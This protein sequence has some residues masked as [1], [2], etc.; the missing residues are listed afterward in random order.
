M[1]A[2]SQERAGIS[3]A[4][5]LGL[6]ALASC[7]AGA[8]HAAAIGAHAEHHQAVVTFT[9]VAIVQIGFG[10]VALMNPRRLFVLAGLLANAGF[11]VGWAF[12]K[13][14]GIGF[15]DGLE[16]VEPAQ[17]ADGVAAALA[18]VAVIA[19]GVA[20]VSG[21]RS[22]HLWQSTL[23]ISTVLTTLVATPAMVSAGSHTHAG[24]GHSHG[25]DTAAAAPHSHATGGAAGGDTTAVV[26]PK[27]YDPTK[28]IDLGGVPG[29]TPEQQARAE[30][31]IAITLLR[32]PQFNDPATAEAAGFRSIGDAVTGDEHYINLSYFKDG[33]ILDPD[34]PESLVYEPDGKG[35]KKLAAAMFM[36]ETG[37]TLADVPDIGGKLTQ[38][39]IHN[40][41]CFT[42]TGRVA[43][44]TAA[45]GSCPPT[46][47]KG[48]ETPMIHVWLRPHP[49]G[50]FAAL[51][52][53]GGG[54]IA[55]GETRLC[56]HQHGA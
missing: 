9:I 49:C 34:H 7:G 32:L 39:H 12:A 28:P 44:L 22:V 13:T 50:P 26:P 25:T 53:I 15:I 8:I 30:N 52:G 47:V 42:T 33:R 14:S 16:T 35:G 48:P 6:A 23:A 37:Q 41:L 1:L 3:I 17:F 10:V 46:L 43:A 20:L 29:V 11:F 19:A 24:S 2:A 18:A 51:E 55:E 38:W 5:A 4:P 31:L 36:L 27:P 54:Q 56:D 45:D 21:L 40:N